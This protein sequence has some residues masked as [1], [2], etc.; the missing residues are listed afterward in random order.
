MNIAGAIVTIIVLG[1]LIWNL[2][3]SYKA[4]MKKYKGE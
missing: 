4:M 3:T 1:V 2:V